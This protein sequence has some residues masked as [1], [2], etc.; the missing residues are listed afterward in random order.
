MILRLC[1]SLDHALLGK[2]H[3][4]MSHSAGVCLRPAIACA[5]AGGSRRGAASA[6]SDGAPLAC[7]DKIVRVHN[8][9]RASAGSQLAE[10]PGA[11]A[12]ARYTPA[13]ISGRLSS[14]RECRH[15]LRAFRAFHA[16]RSLP[17]G[18]REPRRRPWSRP[19]SAG[20]RGSA[21]HR[22]NTASPFH[23]DGVG[24]AKAPTDYLLR[25]GFALTAEALRPLA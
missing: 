7:R 17:L 3:D 18:L 4:V 22:A 9:E 20:L 16:R 21:S 2:P 6:L 5:G 24:Y 1:R 23:A 13:S 14:H 10:Q 8:R 19:A 11:A 25:P 12:R 15:R